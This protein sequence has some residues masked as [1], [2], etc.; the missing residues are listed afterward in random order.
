[1]KAAQIDPLKFAFAAFVAFLIIPLIGWY[2]FG[3]LFLDLESEVNRIEVWDMFLKSLRYFI[4][5]YILGWTY[6][7]MIKKL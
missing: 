1:M 7:Y 2:F 5:F 4:T 6:N 3:F